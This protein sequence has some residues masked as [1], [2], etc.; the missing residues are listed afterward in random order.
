[1]FLLVIDDTP[2]RKQNAREACKS[3]AQ[4][5]RLEKALE[6]FRNH[7]LA[8]FK[9]WYEITFQ[10]EKKRIEAKNAEFLELGKIQNQIV[11]ESH[12]RDISIPDAYRVISDESKAYPTADESTRLKIDQNRA[13]RAAFVESQRDRK[14]PGQEREPDPVF[15]EGFDFSDLSQM[16]EKELRILCQDE[17]QAVEM[18]LDVY[19]GASREK[20]FA[21]FL[22]IWDCTPATTQKKFSRLFSQVN[23]FSFKDL[24]SDWRKNVE[25]QKIDLS[26]E[27]LKFLYRKLVRLLHPD[28]YD[29]RAQTLW[30]RS[31]WDRTQEAYR[32]KNTGELRKIHQVVLLR[33]GLLDQLTLSEIH[34]G[35]VWITEQLKEL[36]EASK[37][38]KRD[39]AWGFSRKKKLEPL[40][41]KVRKKLNE[42]LQGIQSR[43]REL[44][45]SHSFLDM[46]SRLDPLEPRKK[47]KTKSRR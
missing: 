46:L 5:D 8:Q 13:E 28:K 36:Q 31:A 10:A 42:E 47:R 41:A 30:H 21:L 34:Q 16:S 12:L 2:L 11:A 39:L 24:L 19:H 20:E 40:A 18:L 9:S 15:E 33:S 6:E 17:E 3:L 43:V 26:H 22:K 32:A 14:A 38:V 1:M 44:A 35:G 27:Q 25:G 7:D 29:S 37:G 45:Q 4:I 23:G